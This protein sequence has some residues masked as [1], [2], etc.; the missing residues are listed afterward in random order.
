MNKFYGSLLILIS[1][2]GYALLYALEKKVSS[3]LPPFTLM[4]I[5]MFVLFLISLVA[6]VFFENGLH[7]RWEEH[8]SQIGILILV[9]V[10]NFIAFWLLIEGYKYM[11]IWQQSMFTL[12][13]PVLAGIFAYFILGEKMSP[14]LFIGLAI[15]GI[16]LFITIRY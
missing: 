16:G 1:T 9:G 5:S 13:T 15:M 8:R 3:K 14:M 12:L 11:P 2:T 4:A 6:A 10:I 7:F